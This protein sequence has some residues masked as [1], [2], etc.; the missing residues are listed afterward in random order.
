MAD[1]LERAGFEVKPR[2]HAP[3]ERVGRVGGRPSGEDLFEAHTDVVTEGSAEDWDHPPFGPREMEAVS[4]G[5]GRATPRGTWR[6][7]WWPVLLKD[8]GVPFPAA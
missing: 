1:Y 3:S 5:A 7:P 8:S 2:G 4:T 6:R